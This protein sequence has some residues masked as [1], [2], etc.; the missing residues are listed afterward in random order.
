MWNWFAPRCPL[1][2]WEKTWTETRMCWLA[3]RFGI[4][5]LKGAE[6]ILPTEEHFPDPYP[7]GGSEDGVRQMMERLCQYMQIDPQTI[8]LRVCPDEEMDDAAGTWQRDHQKQRGLIRLAE[9]RLTDPEGLLATLAHELAHELLHGNDLLDHSISDH[10]WITDLLPVYLGVG[11][12]A[13]NSTIREA[14]YSDGNMSWWAM[15]RRGY[16]PSR[17]LGYGLALFAFMRDELQPAWASHLRLD[18]A[19]ALRKGLDYLRKTSDSH[20]HPDSIQTTRQILTTS[21]AI[22]RLRSKN[23]S[24]RLATLWE[25]S[26]SEL[27]DPDC[28]EAI[29]ACLKDRDHDIPGDAAHVLA[30]FGPHAK[31]GVPALLDALRLGNEHTRAGAAEA[32]GGLLQQPEVVV[33]ELCALIQEEDRS[34]RLNTAWALGRYGVPLEPRS[35]RRLVGALEAALIDCD[36]DLGEVLVQALLAVTTDP[37]GSIREHFGNRDEELLETALQGLEELRE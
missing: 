7:P 17:I 20:F 6:V 22:H 11:V 8:E 23:A 13:A 29:T 37:E 3:E 2:T 33:P 1:G 36:Y 15:S 28:L 9:S 18:A 24:V 31:A 5:R 10:E 16:L 30:K 27:Y 19:S 21:E 32:L 12:F 25:I 34:L 35:V 26:D 14:N 4:E